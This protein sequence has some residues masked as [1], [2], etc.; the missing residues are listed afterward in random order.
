MTVPI[1]NTFEERER[2]RKL[3]KQKKADS[4]TSAKRKPSSTKRATVKGKGKGKE[5]ISTE[6]TEPVDMDVEETEED[7]LDWSKYVQQYD[8]VITTYAVLRSDFNVARASIQRPRR[9][10]V[11][12]ANV[13]RP[14]SPL[15]MVEWVRVIMD[16]VQMVGGGKTEYVL[17]YSLLLSS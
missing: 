16:E 12:Y 17:L 3:L 1:V 14:R 7:F 6:S 11:S 13:E 8:I 9:E 5:D 15:V 4:K 10:D 2:A